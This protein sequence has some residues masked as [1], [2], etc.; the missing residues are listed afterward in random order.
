MNKILAIFVV[1]VL[2]VSFGS[3]YSLA[4]TGVVFSEDFDDTLDGWLLDSCQILDASQSCS[5]V[6]SEFAQPPASY[7]PLDPAISD[8]YWG[9]VKI[10]DSGGGTCSGPVDARYSKE[11][12][13]PSNG[14][15]RIES[16]IGVTNCAGCIETAT[17]YID[18]VQIFQRDGINGSVDPLTNQKLFFESL[19]LNLDQGTHEIG[20]GLASTVTCGGEFHAAFDNILVSAI[21]PAITCGSGTTLIGNECEADVTQNDLDS[22]NADLTIADDNLITCNTDLTTCNA[23]LSSCS[24]DLTTANE[25]LATCNGDLSTCSADLTMA[26]DDL[27]MCIGDLGTAQDDITEL[28]LQLTGQTDIE[29]CH[30]PGTNQE[31]TIQ[32]SVQQLQGHLNHGDIFDA[33]AAP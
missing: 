14:E 30:K 20:I 4:G 13:A 5:I 15:Y 1:L 22:C 16:V 3:Q 23:N 26:T 8:P 18:G 9:V 33:C 21:T 28:E 32:V 2:L 31:N 27:N 19:D 24:D 7:H 29:I 12:V 25:D 10:S 11:F 17:L 6:Q